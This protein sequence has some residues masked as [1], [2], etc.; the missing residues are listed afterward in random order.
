[1]GPKNKKKEL[2]RFN[3]LLYLKTF[4]LKEVKNVTFFFPSFDLI[5]L[6]ITLKGKRWADSFLF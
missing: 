5:Y 1:M 4:Q 2:T 6:L 3:I